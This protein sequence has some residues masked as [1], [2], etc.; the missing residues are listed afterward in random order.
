MERPT[1]LIVDDDPGVHEM[2]SDVLS[3]EGYAVIAALNGREALER[4]A[5]HRPD[6]ILLDLMM[7]VMDGW[8]F[9]EEMHRLKGANDIPVV[10]LSATHSI[11]DA[12]KQIQADGYIAKPFDLD[13]LLA[14]LADY[15]PVGGG[16]RHRI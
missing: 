11:V 4:L 12:A 14:K 3:D 9:R 13:Q 10:V 8:R 2:L 15:A 5:E 16:R 7:P 6:V 1:V